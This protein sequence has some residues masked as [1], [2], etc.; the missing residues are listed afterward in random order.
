MPMRCAV[1]YFQFMIHSLECLKLPF[2]IHHV[3]KNMNTH[4]SK[5]KSGA[6]VNPIKLTHNWILWKPLPLKPKYKT[7]HR[8]FGCVVIC[9]YIFLKYLYFWPSN[10]CTCE[11]LRPLNFW[12]CGLLDIRFSV[13]VLYREETYHTCG[14]WNFWTFGLLTLGPLGL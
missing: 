2:T 9:A 14:L 13:R 4:F 10:F 7:H 3:Q 1:S 6:I 11:D 8:C 12:A 5:K